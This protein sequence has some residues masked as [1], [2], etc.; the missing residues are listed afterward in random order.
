MIQIILCCLD[1]DLGQL[2]FTLSFLVAIFAESS[3]KNIAIKELSILVFHVV[4]LDAD[5][6]LLEWLI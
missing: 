4:K 5:V 1:P 6:S 2:Y 3:H